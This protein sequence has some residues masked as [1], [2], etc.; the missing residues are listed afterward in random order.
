MFSEA[1]SPF[2]EGVWIDDDG[3]IVDDRYGGKKKC[4]IA[5]KKK[6]TQ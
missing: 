6:K 1:D 5:K 2:G 3:K 4:L